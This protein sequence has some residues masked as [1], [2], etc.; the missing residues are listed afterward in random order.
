[1]SLNSII[2]IA[3]TRSEMINT[4]HAYPGK[5]IINRVGTIARPY[6]LMRHMARINAK[7][8]NEAGKVDIFSTF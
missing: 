2:A 7:S 4:V 3:N 6:D 8:N 5:L 1:M